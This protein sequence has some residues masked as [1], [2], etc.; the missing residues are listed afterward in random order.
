MYGAWSECVR[1]WTICARGALA[2]AGRARRRTGTH[3][4]DGPVPDFEPELG[5]GGR[6]ERERKR[7]GQ[8]CA[9]HAAGAWKQPGR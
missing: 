7:K 1:S 9:E 3:A 2:R 8:L 5:L 6:A 4:L